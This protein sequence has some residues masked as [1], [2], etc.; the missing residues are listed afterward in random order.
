[1]PHVSLFFRDVGFHGRIQRMRKQTGRSPTNYSFGVSAGRAG[2]CVG[3]IGCT[4]VIGEGF[5]PRSSWPVT[6]GVIAGGFR[7][8][9]ARAIA[10]SIHF[11]S[12]TAGH[13]CGGGGVGRT[14]V[15]GTGLT[16][17]PKSLSFP[18]TSGL[19]F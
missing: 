5:K 8:S 14:G 19:A 15:I 3:W 13:G 7:P 10:P 12:G 18:L 2:T 17:F 1:V 9:F 16:P 11:F 4:G 6:S